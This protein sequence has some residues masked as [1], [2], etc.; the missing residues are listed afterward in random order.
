MMVMI[1]SLIVNATL[2]LALALPV[3]AWAADQPIVYPVPAFSVNANSA[4]DQSADN[5]SP[6][7]IRA[8]KHQLYLPSKTPL[9]LEGYRW[10]TTRLKIYLATRNH[11]L[12]TAFRDA[13]KAWNST[14]VIHLTWT[15]HRSQADIIAEAGDLSANQAAPGV[16]VVTTQLGST[17]SEYNPDTHALIQARSTLDVSHLE[18]ANR[19]FRSE[20]AQHELGHALGLAH[21][22]QGSHSVM[23]PNNVRTG[24]TKEDRQTIRLL[25]GSGD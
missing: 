3:T 21:A 14:G 17:R 12:V 18:Y 25:Y 5:D 13:V 20:V 1:K 7:A 10:P 8:A 19:T 24:I 16:G 11:P 15:R 23:I 6:Q 22:P 4:T 2:V 9:P